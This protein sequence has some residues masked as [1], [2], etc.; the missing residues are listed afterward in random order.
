MVASPDDRTGD[1]A[2]RGAPPRA[3]RAAPSVARLP[4]VAPAVAEFGRALR[5]LTPR[6]FVTEAL[7]AANVL[8]YVIMVARGVSPT[9]PTVA[10]LLDWG[11]GYGP[12]T[13]G[14]EWWRLL[15]ATFL[16]IGG[17]HLAMNMY[18]L[19]TSGRLVERMLGNAGFLLLY[20]TAGL[21]GSVASVLWSPYI[22]SAGASGA[23]FGV[24]GGL[25]GFLVRERA[26]VPSDALKT[27]QR[28]ALLFLGYNL[29][30]GLSIKGIDMAAHLGGLA[31]GCVA[32]LVLAHPLDAQ[33]ARRRWLRNA[34]LAAGTAAAVAAVTRILP[35]RLDVQ[36]ELERVSAVETRTL[37]V[38]NHA[39]EEVKADRMTESQL[40]FEV[41]DRVLPEWHTS[42]E[43]LAAAKALPAAQAKLVASLLAYMTVRE[44]A[45]RLVS[46]AGH[47]HD[48]A[49]FRQANE[50][51][52][53]ASRLA[54]EIGATD[55]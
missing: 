9:K 29:V 14:G 36:A 54:K 45:F 4:A 21:S 47:K 37:D 13:T 52:E 48:A 1:R 5:A 3:R 28:S 17:F 33:G 23:V 11:A 10:E 43:R 12:R 53:E 20:L 35:P 30:F 16:H 34:I 55:K 49:L 25:L 31:G 40:A 26:S 15:T 50:K 6:G 44:E 27:L 24:Y 38:F 19:W 42:R 46:E 51:Q 41:D 22:V 39:L 32:G 8:V 2:R 18:V 7:I